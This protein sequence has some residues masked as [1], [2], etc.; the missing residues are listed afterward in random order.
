METLIDTSD[1][2][3]MKRFPYKW[4]IRYK[5]EIDS[6]YAQ[7]YMKR[8]GKHHTIQLHRFIL[9]AP[10]HLEVDHN[11]HNTLDNRRSQISLATRSENEQNKGARKNSKSG[12]RGVHWDK[13][14]KRWRA[15]VY[16]NKK[17]VWT[18]TFEKLE[19]AIREV[20]KAR[21]IYFPFSKEARNAN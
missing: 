17:Y 1:L 4:G 10:P 7:G 9:D 14:C 11:N 12:V 13:S 15:R 21:A 6:F 18:G 2:E 16:S 5:K 8:A 19:D 20:E 3:K